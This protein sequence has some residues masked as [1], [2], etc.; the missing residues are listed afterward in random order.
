MPDDPDQGSCHQHQWKIDCN[1]PIV[2]S[3]RYYNDTAQTYVNYCP[4]GSVGYPI[5]VTIPIGG[6]YGSSI[7]DANAAAMYLAQL[8]ASLERAY[9]PCIFPFAFFDMD[10][11]CAGEDWLGCPIYFDPDYLYAWDDSEQYQND[12]NLPLIYSWTLG[13][14]PW[15][16]LSILFDPDNYYGWDD[17][18]AYPTGEFDNNLI[19]GGGMWALV[20]GKTFYLDYYFAL[21]NFLDEENGEVTIVTSDGD[22]NPFDTGNWGTDGIIF[23]L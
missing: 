10:D 11:I 22:E 5:S 7:A 15:N 16:P 23:D 8:Q 9:M 21:S 4:S 6:A 13:G 14:G 17:F 2:P 19:Y 3:I 18:E 12:P 20:S 1:G